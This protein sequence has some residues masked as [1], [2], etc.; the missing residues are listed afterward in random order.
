L[1]RCHRR[2]RYKAS[3]HRKVTKGLHGFL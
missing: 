1:S 3:K 2:H